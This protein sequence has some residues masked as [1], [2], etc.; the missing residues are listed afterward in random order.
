[1]A[2]VA[3]FVIHIKNENDYENESTFILVVSMV[4]GVILIV[5]LMS[6]IIYVFCLADDVV[7]GNY[8]DVKIQMYTEENKVI[9]TR[10]D[11]LVEKYMN[12]ES[13]TY[14]ELKDDDAIA[15]VSLYPELK[16]GELVQKQI[17][18]YM[19]NNAK[20]KELKEEKI[21]ASISRWWLYFGK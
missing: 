1:M 13:D 15:L 5:C 21:N 20:I 17:G 14:K 2:T 7:S 9:E 3:C 16:A 4:C 6:A 8:I 18:V 10:I 19:E 11:S 12:Y